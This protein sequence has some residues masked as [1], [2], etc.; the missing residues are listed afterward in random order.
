MT[1][2]HERAAFSPPT[3]LPAFER[4]DALL[5]LLASHRPDWDEIA[6]LILRDPALV[7]SILEASPLPKIR[8]VSTLR[9]ELVQRL[10]VLGGN[11]LRGWLLLRARAMPHDEA[12]ARDE[13]LLVAEC[14]L[15]LA[16]ET[17]YPYPDEAY[18]AGLW[19]RL[20][21][22][23]PPRTGTG[24]GTAE[25]ADVSNARGY[26]NADHLASCIGAD[27][28]LAGPLFD[29]LAMQP[30]LEEDLA[31]AHPL[32]RLLGV[33][34]ALAAEGWEQRLV[35]LAEISGLPA[36]VLLSLRT[37]VGFIV[38][39]GYEAPLT[40]NCEPFVTSGPPRDVLCPPE[41]V[42]APRDDL[43]DIAVSALIAGAFSGV[44]VDGVAAR[45]SIA[46]RLLARQPSPLVIFANERGGL[47]PVPLA[48]DESAISGWYAELAQHVDDATSVIALTARSGEPALWF[49][50]RGGTGRSTSDRC[51][52]RWLGGSGIEC[53]PLHLEGTTAVAVIAAD[54]RRPLAPAVRRRLVE[55]AGAAA[56]RV[57]EIRKLEAAEERAV[58][59]VE[60][61][62]REHARKLAHEARN[63]LTVIKSYL[64]IMTQRHP[65]AAGLT[66]N[67][68]I[69]HSELD[70]VASLLQ[71]AGAAPAP[72]PEPAC[73]RVPELLNDLRRLYGESLFD[74]R[75][76][77]LELRV[78]AGMP[79]VAMPDSALRQ[80]LLN[81][82][83]NASEALQPGGRFAVTVPGQV[84][85]NGVAC[86]EIRLIDNGPGLEPARLADL[87]TPRP[88]TK[89]SDHDGLGLSI[90]RE[91]VQQWQGNILCRSQSGT[92]TSFQLLLPLDVCAQAEAST[93]E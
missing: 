21:A 37:D 11:L 12:L 7:H 47:E 9:T 69:L 67:I 24:P 73:C 54:E 78:A 91:I 61:R 19:H 88:S 74:S 3:L 92:G 56:H 50:T 35:R 27:C 55:L 20:G 79:A 57:R 17:R 87:F 62:Y 22:L 76:I 32:V 70:R 85:S 81:L 31:G 90:V 65:E 58:A 59:A 53:L 49:A 42:S 66:G 45:L 41:A 83:R 80:V 2:P 28:G 75:G 93:Y 33:A 18:L 63:P 4:R 46:S 82:F 1:A 15:H 36:E 34:K 39:R 29:A 30:V 6:S 84:L 52:A 5:R 86:L 77:R 71:R 8:L 13:A 44:D 26:A 64:G 40:S 16:H 60:A 23:P 10:Q 43:S 68:D 25:V 89:G 72:D 14:A 48:G 38:R 51:V